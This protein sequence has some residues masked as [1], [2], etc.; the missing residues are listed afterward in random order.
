LI[1]RIIEADSQTGGNGENV[2]NVANNKSSSSLESLKVADLKERC[3]ELGLKVS[4]TKKELIERLENPDSAENR[5]KGG[6]EQEGGKKK[7][8]SKKGS[9]SGNMN[10]NAHGHGGELCLE[11]EHCKNHVNGENAH[12]ICAFCG[13]NGGVCK[14]SRLC[15]TCAPKVFCMM[16]K[17]KVCHDSGILICGICFTWKCKDPQCS[18]NFRNCA[19]CQS[20]L[21]CFETCSDCDDKKLYC[22]DKCCDENL[23]L[24]NKQDTYHCAEHWGDKSSDDDD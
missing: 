18:A 12:D 19:Q 6:A 3:R 11:H 5:K 9:S 7:T 13:M 15:S 8:S 22:V 21:C 10:S 4:G 17:K 14:R 2:T 1:E 23:K 20:P 24:Y 16:C